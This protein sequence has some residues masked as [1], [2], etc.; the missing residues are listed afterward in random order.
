ME[1]F[2]AQLLNGLVYGVLLFLMAAGL[3][4]IFGLMNVVSLVHGSFFMLGAFFGFSIFRITGSFLLALVLAPIPVIV[5]GILMELLF[6]RPLYRR[7][8]VDQVLLTFGFTFVFL[9]LVQTLWGRTVLRLPVPEALQGTVQIGLGVFSAYR[10]FLIGFG[11][12]IAL[13][14]WL[15]LERSRIGA[16]VRAGVDN[17]AMAAGLG[18]NIPALFTGIFGFGVA[19]AALGG[20]AAAPVLGLYPGMDTEILIPAFIV[21]VI[22]GM[23]SLRGAFVGSLLIGIADT[24][25]KAYFQSIALFLIYLAM[26]AVLLIRPQGLFGIKY[27]DVSVAPAVTTTNRPTTMQRRTGE[28]VALLA[29]L[30]LPFLMTD[31]PRALVS[32]IFIFAIFAMSLDLLLGFTGLM[33]LGHAAFFGLGAYAV[34]VLGAQFGINAWVGV[35]AGVAV[36]GCGAA[37]IGFF[38]VRTGGIPFL[39]LTLAFSQ[40]VYSAALRWRDVTGGSDGL[41][42]ADKP[43]FFGYDLSNSLVMYFMALSFFVLAYWG[44]RRLL[45]APLGHAFVGIRENEQ[46]MMA[47]GYPTRAY[48]LL[49]FTIAGAIAGLAGGLYAIFNGFISAD[50]VYWTASGDILIMTMLGGAGTLIGPAV[51]TAIFLLLKN[52]VSSYSEHWLSIIGITFICCVMFFPGGVWGT[53]RKVQWR[54]VRQ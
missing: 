29:L 19:L 25:G 16:M 8:H 41:A 23:G 27:S 28:L 10:L 44:L 30:V 38:C 54:R 52:V 15:L 35:A 40:L 43:S 6:L 2:V 49:S 39:M 3:S 7:G 46:R 18:A 11:F 24:F 32:E 33:S 37:L 14:L 9:D 34:A 12:A 5:L 50:A 21:I 1:L 22:G 53:L 42:I 31:Y 26:T 47:I 17:A 36:A 51:G 20:I 48:K 13:L 45:N 4:L